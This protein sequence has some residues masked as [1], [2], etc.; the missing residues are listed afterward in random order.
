MVKIDFEFESEYGVY[1]DAIV[2][3]EDHNLD[4][5]EIDVIKQQRFDNW[6]AHIVA[7][8]EVSEEEIAA[9]QIEEATEEPQGE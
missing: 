4:D 9:A 7:A 5:A 1:R 2:L 8:S 6:E 3:P